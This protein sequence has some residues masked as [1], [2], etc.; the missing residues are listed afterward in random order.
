MPSLVKNAAEFGGM[1][2]LTVNL[3]PSILTLLAKQG[4]AGTASTLFV[5][6]KSIMVRSSRDD[7]W[8]DFPLSNIKNSW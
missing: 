8:F 4:T 2:E 1:T 3:P 6:L 5:I 7:L